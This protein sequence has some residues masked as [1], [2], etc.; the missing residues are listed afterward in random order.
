MLLTPPVGLR[1]QAL[2]TYRVLCYLRRVVDDF[3]SSN[4][5]EKK[6]EV[7]TNMTDDKKEEKITCTGKFR[8]PRPGATRASEQVSDTCEKTACWADPK[9]DTQNATGKKNQKKKKTW[10][11]TKKGE[12]VVQG[13]SEPPDSIRRG[14]ISGLLHD[15]HPAIA[16]IDRWTPS[17]AQPSTKRACR[18]TAKRNPT[19]I[20]RKSESD[21]A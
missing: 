20:I 6:T 16:K 7:K 5:R 8:S 11:R 10:K 21:S 12:K 4:G 18:E 13:T 9:T 3:F 19:M 17:H 15:R 2:A 14:V 1:H